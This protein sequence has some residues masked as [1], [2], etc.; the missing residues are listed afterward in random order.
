[1]ASSALHPLFAE[2]LDSFKHREPQM[3]SIIWPERRL[4]SAE[5][6][7]NWFSDAVAD[8]KVDVNQRGV[9]VEDRAYA[10][11]DAGLITLG[12]SL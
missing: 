8:G 5:Q 12:R 7:E 9:C 10:L 11:H 2:I 3:F 6:I 1:M 4:V